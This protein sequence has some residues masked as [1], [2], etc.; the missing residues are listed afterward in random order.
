V[1]LFLIDHSTFATGSPLLNG[2]EERRSP[3]SEVIWPELAFLILGFGSKHGAATDYGQFP[4][5]P[6]C[7]PVHNRFSTA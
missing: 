1:L 5:Y 2:S 4:D 6:F 3:F 7:V